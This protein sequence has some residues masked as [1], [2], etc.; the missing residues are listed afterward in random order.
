MK[1]LSRDTTGSAS[2]AIFDLDG[3]IMSTN[4]IEQY[5]WSR[6][7][8]LSPLRQLREVAVVTGRLPGYL[9]TEQRDRGSFLRAVYRR[10]RGLDLAHLERRVD[11][12]MAPDILSRL[13]PDA[14]ARIEGHR[15][16]GHTTVLLTGAV[17]TLTRP[18]RDLFDVIVAAELD[19]DADG[20]CTGFLTTPPLVGESRAA[21]LKHYAALHQ[22]DLTRSFAYADSHSDLPMLSAVGNP[23]AV[24]PGHFADAGR[25]AVA[26]VN[27]GVEDHPG[28]PA[29]ADPAL[30]L[31]RLRSYVGT[32]QVG[33][34]QAPEGRCGRA[35]GQVLRE[36]DQ[37]HRGRSADGRGRP[38]TGTRRCTTRSRR[39]AR[40]RSPRTTSSGR[41]TWVRRGVGRQ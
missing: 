41:S 13:S 33:H 36:T 10:Y 22:V 32:L 26:V 19:T 30:S 11:T 9:L 3:T 38:G 6:L 21:W 25:S 8:E 34:H 18:L 5:L 16:A 17:S 12:V 7:P 20:I 1:D 35:A 27:R 28:S 39:P 31:D 15:A 23:V 24:S 2:V 4:V 40:P 14:L 29:L 37:E